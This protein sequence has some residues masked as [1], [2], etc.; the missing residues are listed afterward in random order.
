MTGMTGLAQRPDPKSYQR[1]NKA[2]IT[3]LQRT[4]FRGVV[5]VT[6]LSPVDFFVFVFPLVLMTVLGNNPF[7]NLWKYIGY[8]YIGCI[9]FC[10][11]GHYHTRGDICAQFNESI[12]KLNT[13]LHY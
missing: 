3:Y 4:A 2:F 13:S 5:L 10:I 6:Y 11:V 12:L 9:Y 8:F 7:W 1:L